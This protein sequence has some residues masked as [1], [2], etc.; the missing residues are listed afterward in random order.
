MRDG[1]KLR[2]RQGC[3][4]PREPTDAEPIET[5]QVLNVRFIPEVEK[6]SRCF[7]PMGGKTARQG[8]SGTRRLI[9][10][11]SRMTE[12]DIDRLDGIISNGHE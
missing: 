1:S 10:K 11:I 4:W 3:L 9:V 12:K 7:L 6:K 8:R 5:Y 2:R